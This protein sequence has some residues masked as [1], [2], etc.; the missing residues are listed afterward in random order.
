MSECFVVY[1]SSDGVIIR[2]GICQDDMSAKQ[3]RGTEEVAL[4]VLNV[5]DPNRFVVVDGALSAKQEQ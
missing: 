1:R 3:A 2:S 5:V 4:R